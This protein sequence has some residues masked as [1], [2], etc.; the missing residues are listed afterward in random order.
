MVDLMRREERASSP[1]S[2]TATG[3]ETFQIEVS[4]PDIERQKNG[5]AFAGLLV[6]R[7]RWTL[8][9]RAKIMLG[10]LIIVAAV[11][12][13]LGVYP[14]LAFTQPVDSRVLVV[15]G[16]IHSY[17]I[18]KSAE[19]FKNGGY[20]RI[21]TTG[22]PVVGKGGYVNDFQ[23]SASVGADRLKS[24]GIAAVQMVPSRVNGRD[25]TYSSAVALREWLQEHHEQLSSFNVVT[26]GAH[27]RRSRL[28][29]QRAFGPEV[30][31]G[32][33]SIRSPDFDAKHWWYYSEG[34]E[35][36]VQETIAYVYAKFFF[37][38]TRRALEIEKT[39]HQNGQ[40]GKSSTFLAIPSA[41]GPG[42]V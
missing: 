39:K 27:A 23:T 19:E 2:S 11:A 17:A 42:A 25:R 30:R 14:F 36:V 38:T 6:R 37:P 28:M 31:V 8:T 34:T 20:D 21:F 32:V 16:W 4:A 22:G 12:A 29:F 33:I 35:E 7:N 24:A 5:R 1:P 10:L 13:L 3:S 18:E 15:E 26:E 40:K 41:I 9:I